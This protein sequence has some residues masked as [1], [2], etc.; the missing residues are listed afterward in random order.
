MTPEQNFIKKI[1]NIET[2]EEIRDIESATAEQLVDKL[3]KVRHVEYKLRALS[4][5][6]DCSNPEC[7][8]F[9]KYIPNVQN[10][11]DFR[12]DRSK[13]IKNLT[14]SNIDELKE[15]LKINEIWE[16]SGAD[17]LARFPISIMFMRRVTLRVF[18]GLLV[19]FIIERYMTKDLRNRQLPVS[20]H[21]KLDRIMHFIS[22]IFK[23]AKS[24]KTE[25]RHKSKPKRHPSKR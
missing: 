3:N 22:K 23:S 8:D 25:S 1:Q 18:I 9:V 17:Q 10:I 13:E 7:K 2:S 19:I 24:A 5:L 4:I 11:I 15:F 14:L 16:V 20:M 12:M 6:R 21:K